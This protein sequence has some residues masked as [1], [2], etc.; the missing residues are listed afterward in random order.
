MLTDGAVIAERAVGLAGTVDSV[1][2]HGDHPG[3][4]E[5]AREGRRALV[6]AGWTLQG[7]G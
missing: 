2:V 3:A 6:A 5:H 7:L 4:V 1:C